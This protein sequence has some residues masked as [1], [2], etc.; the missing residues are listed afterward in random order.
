MG[1]Y[2]EFCQEREMLKPAD[3]TWFLDV[4]NHVWNTLD[5][6]IRSVK[7]KKLDG[8]RDRANKAIKKEQ[9]LYDA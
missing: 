7:E 2:S 9:E 8:S 1:S 6:L 4:Y 5:A 3:G